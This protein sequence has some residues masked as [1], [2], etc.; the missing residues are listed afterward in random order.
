MVGLD[1]WLDGWLVVLRNDGDRCNW[2]GQQSRMQ[3]VE[4][5]WGG[6]T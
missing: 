3:P 6:S 1:G 4:I 5:L 2:S